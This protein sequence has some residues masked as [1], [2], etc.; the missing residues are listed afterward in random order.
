[1]SAASATA[2]PALK[3]SAA[4]FSGIVLIFGLVACAPEPGNEA[5][6]I[7]KAEETVSP[8]TQWDQANEDAEKRTASL[9]ET[10]PTDD[11]AL[12]VGATIFDAGERGPD[13]WYLVLSAADAAAAQTVWSEV[14]SLNG[15]KVSDEATAVDDGITATLTGLT[16][17]TAAVTQPLQDGSVLLNYDITRWG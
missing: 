12:P 11:F 15:F 5:G 16:L 7:N 6:A 9:P 4:L 8:E 10:F 2:H 1:M 17:S 14:I 3:Y 13:S